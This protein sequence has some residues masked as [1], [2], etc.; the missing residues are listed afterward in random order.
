LKFHLKGEVKVYPTEDPEKV[1]TAV[2]NLFSSVKISLEEEDNIQTLIFESKKMES[3]SKIK[4]ILRQDQIRDAV[5]KFLNEKIE[6][7][8]I[9]FYLNKQVA[10]A[11]HVSLCEPFGESPL[12]PIKVEIECKD[13][14]KLVDWLSPSSQQEYG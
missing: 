5:R 4:A 6:G 9:G 3:L 12:G 8:K 1:R 10:Y 2:E 11:G 13:P 7:E 14:K